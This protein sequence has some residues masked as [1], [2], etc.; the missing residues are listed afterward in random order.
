MGAS[1][2]L[3]AEANESGDAVQVRLAASVV[4]D[5]NEQRGLA[6]LEVVT[7]A[8]CIGES[9]LAFRGCRAGWDLGETKA[10][11]SSVVEL[12]L[13]TSPVDENWNVAEI[14]FLEKVDGK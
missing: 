4:L 1:L 11:A 2:R 6:L 3:E 13:T 12:T 5:F 10:D 14:A 7:N 9:R 8:K